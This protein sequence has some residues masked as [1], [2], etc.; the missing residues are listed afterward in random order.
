MSW[1]ELFPTFRALPLAWEKTPVLV[2]VSGGPDS[3]ALTLAY[4]A[5][6]EHIAAAAPWCAVTVDHGLRKESAQEAKQVACW[7]EGRG[8]PHAILTWFHGPLA[9]Q[10]EEQARQARYD[11][12]TDFAHAHGFSV[13]LTGHQALDQIETVLMRATRGAGL[14][15]LRGMAPLSK[16]RGIFVARPFLTLFPEDLRRIL[17]E[18]G[19]PFVNDPSNASTQFERVRWRKALTFFGARGVD[20][21]GV[22]RSI[23]NLQALDAQLTEAAQAF[24]AAQVQTSE[25]GVNFSLDA[26]QSL[27]PAV[28]ECVLRTLLQEVSQDGSPCAQRVLTR[29]WEKLSMPSF[30]GATAHHCVLHRVRA[31]RVL[32]QREIRPVSAGSW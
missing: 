2:A 6:R 31:G 17:D 3:L 23:Q 8:I 4:Q 1:S 7:L 20:L 12:L 30:K 28:G 10:I 24:I 14:M 19:Q 15:G 27:L 9:S 32:I 22:V 16:Q 13:L 11:L 29:L 21:R 18:V 26:F 5:F 25:D